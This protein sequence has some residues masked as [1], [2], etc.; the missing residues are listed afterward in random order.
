[1][2]YSNKR[3]LPEI[4]GYNT[5]QIRIKRSG[6]FGSPG[7]GHIDTSNVPSYATLPRNSRGGS[8]RSR[9]LTPR[10]PH[11]NQAR[12]SGDGTGTAPRGTGTTPRPPHHNAARMFGDS[13]PGTGPTTV[14]S[15]TLP[16]QPRPV[17]SPGLNRAAAPLT[18]DDPDKPVTVSIKTI[19]RMK[20]NR[21]SQEEQ[22]AK[23]EARSRRKVE[24]FQST[25]ADKIK[26]T[27]RDLEAYVQFYEK[28]LSSIVTDMDSNIAV[29]KR[30]KDNLEGK[31]KKLL[32]A[33]DLLSKELAV[34]RR[35]L[36]KCQILTETP[37]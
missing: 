36:K 13:N 16:R 35:D 37:V 33:N 32:D 7:Q 3:D 24:Y 34:I 15:R 30:K 14:H 25:P 20:I 23:K 29:E 9:S 2:E 8:R 6:Q 17:A 18:A 27:Q 1:M 10:S 31:L 28:K 21:I 22:I 4:K 26:V 12:V 11:L 5:P 19:P